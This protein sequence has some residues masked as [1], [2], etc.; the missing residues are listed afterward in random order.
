MINAHSGLRSNLH[1]VTVHQ[2]C[3]D[4]RSMRTYANLLRCWKELS[5]PCPL[6]WRAFV[7]K[8]LSYLNSKQRC[9]QGF[10]TWNLK[11]IQCVVTR[12]APRWLN[13]FV[14]S[15][16]VVLRGFVSD[17]PT[18]NKALKRKHLYLKSSC[19]SWSWIL[20]YVVVVNFLL[21]LRILLETPT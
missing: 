8:Q 11:N 17:F 19:G 20:S 10:I 21:T 12:V 18:S 14:S 9:K 15:Q 1:V 3:R 2:N 5:V 7:H 16:S 4:R 6:D 13:T